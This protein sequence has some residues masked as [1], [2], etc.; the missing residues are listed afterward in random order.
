MLRD[1]RNSKKK[2]RKIISQTTGQLAEEFAARYLNSQGLKIIDRNFSGRTGEIDLIAL[3]ENLLVFVEVRLRNHHQYASGAES[4]NFRKQ[5]KLITTASLY[6]QQNYANEPR[7]CRF[8]VVSMK[9]KGDNNDNYEVD[10]LQDAF[11]PEY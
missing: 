1:W 11:R 4:V 3:Q 8:D 9:L 2:Q 7:P 6:L 5:R 10:W